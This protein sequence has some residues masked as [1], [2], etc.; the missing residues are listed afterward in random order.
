[1]FNVWCYV[2]LLQGESTYLNRKYFNEHYFLQG[3][4]RWYFS[5]G[6]H[7]SFHKSTNPPVQ[8][9]AAMAF[10]FEFVTTIEGIL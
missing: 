4:N 2:E 9:A 1:M 5:R 3:M 7:Q 10:C 8:S 6:S